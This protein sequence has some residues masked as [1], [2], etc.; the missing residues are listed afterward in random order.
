VGCWP[1]A[2]RCRPRSPSSLRVA[3]RRVIA[4]AP[5]PRSSP[6]WVSGSSEPE[7]I[8][9][10]AGDG[11][12]RAVFRRG[13]PPAG[14]D[15]GSAGTSRERPQ[16]VALANRP[17]EGLNPASR[18]GRALVLAR[19]A[20]ASPPARR[21]TAARATPHLRTSTAT[22]AFMV[23]RSSG[24]GTGNAPSVAVGIAGSGL[25]GT[26]A[27][28][29]CDRHAT[30]ACSVEPRGWIWANSE[31]TS[32]EPRARSCRALSRRASARRASRP[33]RSR[34]AMR[35]PPYRW[36]RAFGGGG[37]NR[38]SDHRGRPALAFP[39]VAKRPSERSALGRSF[40]AIA[41]RCGATPSSA[42]RFC[43]R[44]SGPLAN[45]ARSRATS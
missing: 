21:P 33:S 30:T 44:D 12:G 5:D 16:P 29:E 8:H 25:I 20:Q 3:C 38:R 10:P 41:Q 36:T 39:S 32:D 6:D 35:T 37:V 14:G 28:E 18:R 17:D 31:A 9:S 15:V 22:I 19:G 45:R 26:T 27:L 4:S 34:F 24:A 40:H 7:S 42:G 23:E 13:V 11:P 1:S 2:T 43:F